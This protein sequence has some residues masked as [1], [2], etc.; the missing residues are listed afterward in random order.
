ME[1]IWDSKFK[2]NLQNAK[3]FQIFKKN[4]YIN[5]I[6]L[7]YILDTFCDRKKMGIHLT[8]IYLALGIYTEKSNIKD[9]KEYKT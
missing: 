1:F 6:L 2:M 4:I 3:H 7:G 9:Y 5:N 8:K